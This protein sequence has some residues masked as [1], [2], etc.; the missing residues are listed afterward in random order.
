MLFFIVVA[1]GALLSVVALHYYIMFIAKK[2]KVNPM[3]LKFEVFLVFVP[4]VIVFLLIGFLISHL[5]GNP[6]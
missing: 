5:V 4:P 6:I 3:I 1:I 2:S